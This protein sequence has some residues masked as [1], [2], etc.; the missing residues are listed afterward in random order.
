MNLIEKLLSVDKAKVTEKET[1]KIKSKKLAKLV[2]EDAEITR[3][4][5]QCPSG[6]VI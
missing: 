5:I 4:K 3:E 1:K 2:G 6:H